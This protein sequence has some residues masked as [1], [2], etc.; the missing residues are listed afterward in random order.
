MVPLVIAQILQRDLMRMVFG[1]RIG[2]IDDSRQG[3]TLNEIELKHKLF[4]I[5]IIIFAY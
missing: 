5:I 3:V 2:S 1:G 4:I